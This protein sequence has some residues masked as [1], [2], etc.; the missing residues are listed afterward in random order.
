MAIVVRTVKAMREHVRR[1]HADGKTV[2]VVP[3]MGALHAGHLV[4]VREGFKHADKVVVT[5]FVN[6]KQFAATED[7]GKY[8]RTEDQDLAMLSDAKVDLVFAP[9]ESEM[10]APGFSTSV[11]VEGPALVCLEDKFRP[12][13][14]DGVA[15][16][17]SKLFIQSQADV[18][19]FGEKDYQQLMVVT[20]MARDLDIPIRVIGVPTVRDDDGMAK[21]SRNRYMNAQERQRATAIISALKEAALNIRGGADPRGAAESAA[22]SLNEQG[23]KVDYV[24]ARNANTLE[25]PQSAHEPL[26][27]LA[28]AWLGTTRLID[29]I[30]VVND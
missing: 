29:N 12:H 5:I 10:Y 17:V 28:A 22:Q 4:L 6:P 30:A 2:A 16:V 23:F 24:A 25:V 26:R 3:T 11:H 1:W 7:L 20:R 15:T 27:L 18:A 8:P 9:T 13:F 21:S 19:M 14:F